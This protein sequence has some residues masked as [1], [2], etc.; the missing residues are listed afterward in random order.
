MTVI[1]VV[2]AGVMGVGVAQSLA[3]TGHDVVLI[4]MDEKILSDARSTIWRNCRMSR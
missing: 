2:G 3:Q 4:D 1:G